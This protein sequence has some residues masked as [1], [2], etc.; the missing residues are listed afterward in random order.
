MTAARSTVSRSTGSFPQNC[1]YAPG[2]F[3]MSM[4]RT[5]EFSPAIASASSIAVAITSSRLIAS[6]VKSFT[7]EGAPSAQQ[8]YDSCLVFH[9]IK[10]CFDWLGTRNLSEPQCGREYFNECGIHG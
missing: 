2:N 3:L 7:H 5:T 1:R 10:I 8:L 6:D 4:P 9:R